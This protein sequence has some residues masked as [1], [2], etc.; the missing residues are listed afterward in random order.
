MTDESAVPPCPPRA[1]SPAPA[2]HEQPA[3]Q[4]D[5]REVFLALLGV[6]AICVL[7]AFDS[8][9]VSTTLP[10]IAEALDGLR[11]YA[12]VGS[13]YLLAT[14]VTIPIFGRMGDL[15]GRRKLLLLSVVVV[16]ICSVA[17]GF[18]QTMEQLV[19][20]R[21]LQG[22]GGGMMIATAFAAPAD[23]LPDPGRRARWQALLAAAFAVASGIGPVL[24]GAITQS[25]GWR[26]T[27]AV[28]PI[29][30]IPTFWAVYRYFP[31]LHVSVPRH[32]R[33]IDWVGGL[34]LMVG[35]GA[36]L[37]ALQFA[38]SDGGNGVLAAAM[39]AVGILALAV[40][41][42]YER[43]A[44][45]PM[46][47]MRVLAAHEA[48]ILNIAGLLVGA[49]MF[50]AIYFGP[51]L[52]QDVLRVGPRDAGLLLTP[53]VVSIPLAGIMNGFLFPRQ[54]QPQRLMVLGAVLLGIGCVAAMALDAG[55]SAY[56]ALLAF[57]LIGLGLGFLL[58]NLTLFMQ[59]IAE[60]R[61]VGV[62]SALIQTTRAIGSAAGI[63]AVGLVVAQTSV[64]TGVR[65]GL[66]ACAASCI[67][68]ALLSLRV[69]MRN[70][71]KPD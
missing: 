32:E 7:V 22:I 8:T 56:W 60:R 19:V 51:L 58:P 20:A 1:E 43:R 46:L 52:L 6:A 53:L 26:P 21:T 62:A 42:P 64:L 57:S 17:C 55:V 40:L 36:P 48:Q 59:M 4:R 69:R 23:L 18:A 5:T 14:A 12:W 9:I 49:I 45:V 27:F 33:R 30:A 66:A 2:F 70:A 41:V 37:A 13:G 50:I 47:P 68:I 61:D 11:L 29:V 25:F 16:G 35:V 67:V 15:F 38:F 63:A 34:L 24:G 54:T 39:L 3:L 28:I 44:P 31:D 10:R 65:I 71:E